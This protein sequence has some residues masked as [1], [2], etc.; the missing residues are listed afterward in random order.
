MAANPEYFLAFV[1][2]V[3]KTYINREEKNE[4]EA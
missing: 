4:K 3:W 1:R 2:P